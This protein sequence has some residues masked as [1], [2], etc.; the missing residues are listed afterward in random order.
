M[1]VNVRRIWQYTLA[2]A[3]LMLVIG[4]AID[5]TDVRRYASRMERLMSDGNYAE[6]LQVGNQS[7][8]TDR[9]LMKLRMKALAHEKLLGERLFAYPV[10]GKGSEFVRQGGDYELC[11]YLIDKRLDDFVRVLPK[12]YKVDA[13]LPRYYREALV[14]YRHL[15]SNPALVYHDAVMDTDY[16]DLQELERMYPKKRARQMAVFQQYEGTYWYYYEYLNPIRR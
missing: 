8:K 9:H 16:Q 10:S 12:Y 6:A 11:A 2:V 14:L 4:I 15:R 13:T 5:T 7:D 3:V 1:R